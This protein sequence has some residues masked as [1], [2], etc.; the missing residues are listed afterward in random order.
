M[1]GPDESVNED[2]EIIHDDHYGIPA[3]WV[4]YDHESGI[5]RYLV[6]VGTSEGT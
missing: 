3:S 6:A 4:G 2:G 1:F 5:V